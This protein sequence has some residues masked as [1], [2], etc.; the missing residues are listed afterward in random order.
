MSNQDNIFDLFS[1]AYDGN[2]QSR[3]PLREYLDSCKTD[4]SLYAS[5]SERMIAAIGHRKTHLEHP[6]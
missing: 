1:K 4:P 6:L 5:A 3:M 2:K